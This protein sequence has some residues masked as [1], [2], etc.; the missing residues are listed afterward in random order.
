MADQPVLTQD[1]WR[2]VAELVR[3]ELDELPSEIHHTDSYEL[4]QSLQKRQRLLEALLA[5][6]APVAS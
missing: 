1:E 6:L 5:K 2:V 3:Q 4:K